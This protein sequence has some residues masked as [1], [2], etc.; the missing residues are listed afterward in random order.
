MH[1][2]EEKPSVQQPRPQLS[3]HHSWR[4]HL[5]QTKERERSPWKINHI[6]GSVCHPSAKGNLG[7]LLHGAVSLSSREL[8]VVVVVVVRSQS[9]VQLFVTPWAAAHQASLSFTISHSLLKFMSIESVMLSNQLILCC[10]PLLLPSI[11]PSIRDFSRG[12]KSC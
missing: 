3:S 4:Q 8:F 9:H 5:T 11:F 2:Q 7:L 10:P 12:L 1:H 6:S